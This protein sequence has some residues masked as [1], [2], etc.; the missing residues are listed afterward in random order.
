MEILKDL[1]YT[2]SNVAKKTVK[3]LMKNWTVIFL[4]LFYMLANLIMLAI[5]PYFWILGGLIQIIVNSALISSYLYV[6]NCII[7]KDRVTLQDFKYGFGVYLRKVWGI[8]FIAY[9][10]SMGINL[11]IL[12]IIGRALS[13]T[14]IALIYYF[15][16]LVL[17][18]PLPETIYQKHYG[19]LDSLSYSISF[20]KDN[21]IEWLIPN[22]LLIGVLYLFLRNFIV[23]MLFMYVPIRAFTNPIVIVF[24][25]IGQIWFTF[26]MI[27]RGYLFDLLSTSNRRKRMFMRRF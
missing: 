15:L 12:P 21:W 25:L 23:A 19:P 7:T 3:S 17:L 8:L 9:V 2:N 16:I 26:L 13:P 14:A 11:L 18:N 24:Y 10:A 27:Y 1:F 20:I 22:A 5:L 4:G 6:M